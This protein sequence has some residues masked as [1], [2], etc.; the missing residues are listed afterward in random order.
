MKFY[1]GIEWKH[2]SWDLHSYFTSQK[3]KKKLSQ[4]GISVLIKATGSVKAADVAAV[5]A[6]LK[7]FSKKKGRKSSSCNTIISARDKEEVG[8]YVY[9]NGTQSA[10]NRFKSKYPKYTSFCTSINNQK[11][12]VH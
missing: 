9:I 10:V 7:S 2:V 6:E 12:Q 8:K 5:N 4:I 11:T 3:Y 1:Y